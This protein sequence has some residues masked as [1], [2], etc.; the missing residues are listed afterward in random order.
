MLEVSLSKRFRGFTLDVAFV[1]RA[2]VSALLGPSGA[3]KSLTLKAIAGAYR[4]DAG[5]IV[6]D[7][8]VLFDA[9]T[10]IERAPQERRVGYVPQDYALFPH[11]DLFHNVAFGLPDRRSPA[12]RRRVMEMLALVGLEGLERRRPH[13]L[14]GG[15]QQRAALARALIVRPATL[16]LDEPFAAL[17]APLRAGL[18]A[19]L[20][21]LQK[22][23]GFRVLLVT[24]DPEDVAALAEEVFH[25]EHGRLVAAG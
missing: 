7:G 22:A 21:E 17:D 1:A 12:A 5:R 15:Q 16:L 18:R 8:E 9:A 2:P 13:E 10:G 4:P 24:H 11:L 19:R 20:R 3:G 23:L 6:L 14:S 25:L